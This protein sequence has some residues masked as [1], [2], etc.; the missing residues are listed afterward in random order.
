LKN[1]P[2]SAVQHRRFFMKWGEMRLISGSMR[3]AFFEPISAFL[4]IF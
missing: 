4:K 3:N 2:V 1:I